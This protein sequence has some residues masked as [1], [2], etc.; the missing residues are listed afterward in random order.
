M[1][2][3]LLNKLIDKEISIMEN[4]NDLFSEEDKIKIAIALRLPK[5]ILW[6]EDIPKDEYRSFLEKLYNHKVD[7]SQSEDTTKTNKKL[8]A[9]DRMKHAIEDIKMN[10]GYLYEEE[11]ELI[12]QDLNPLTSEEICEML[13]KKYPSYN[14][15]YNKHYNEFY[16]ELDEVYMTIFEFYNLIENV[17]GTILIELGKFYKAQEKEKVVER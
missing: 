5:D 17:D 3:I 2:K 16:L 14:I 10:M 6:G 11:Y 4:F 13:K 7:E 1:E 12:K 15:S 8:E 9:L